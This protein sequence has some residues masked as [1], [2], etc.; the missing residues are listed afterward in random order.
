MQMVQSALADAQVSGEL[1]HWLQLS[2]G[3]LLTA[4][5]FSIVVAVMTV[6]RSWQSLFKM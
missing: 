1:G 6:V 5:D 4:A 3:K 2:M